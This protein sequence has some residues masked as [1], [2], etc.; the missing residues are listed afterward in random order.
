MLA[1]VNDAVRQEGVPLETA[2]RVITSSPAEIFQ[3]SGKGRLEIGFDADVVLLDKN[4]S[5]E[6]VMAMGRFFA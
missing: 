3:L 4:L 6:A 2:I 1:E 5:I